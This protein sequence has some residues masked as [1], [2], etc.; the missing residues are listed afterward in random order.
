M[1]S[2][3]LMQVYLNDPYFLYAWMNTRHFHCGEHYWIW[4]VLLEE[5]LF[6]ILFPKPKSPFLILC[7]YREEK[8]VFPWYIKQPLVLM[9]FRKSKWLNAMGFAH[10]QNRTF[11]FLAVFLRLGVACLYLLILTLFKYHRGHMNII[12]DFSRLKSTN[13]SNS[14]KYLN[15]V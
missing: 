10:C 6:L 8:N 1:N 13:T 12:Q 14:N 2:Q 15:S 3:L 4:R 11:S 5:K 7:Q 9:S